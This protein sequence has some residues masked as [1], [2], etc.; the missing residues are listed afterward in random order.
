MNH[1]PI[2]LRFEHTTPDGVTTGYSIK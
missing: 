2:L 1:L